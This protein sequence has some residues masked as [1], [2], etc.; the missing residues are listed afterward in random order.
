[1]SSVSIETQALGV[2]RFW[3]LETPAEKRFQSDER[4]DEEIRARFGELRDELAAFVP[5][6]WTKT[7]ER[8]LAAIILI[9]QFSRNL[10]RGDGE[11]YAADDKG[12]LLA[13][14]AIASGDLDAWPQDRAHF[15]LMPLMHAEDLGTVERCISLMQRYCS[16]LGEA[17]RYGEKHRDVIARY[18]R[19][20][21]RNEA[22]GRA[23][24]PDE[25]DYLAHEGGF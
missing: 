9:D 7:P 14:L 19:Y 13:E 21:S 24:R 23:T 10:H 20:P 12:R 17:I 5:P 2:L 15:V 3:F 22:L 11:A 16:E 8:R 4:L 18:G 25:E 1:M 6:A